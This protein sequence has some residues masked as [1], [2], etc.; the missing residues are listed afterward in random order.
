[1]LKPNPSINDR[2]K[3]LV[4][5]T[6]NYFSHIRKYNSVLTFISFSSILKDISSND[7]YCFKGKNKSHAFSLIQDLFGENEN[8][9]N[10]FQ[11]N[12]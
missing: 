7:L 3:N 5:N 11:Y 9:K 10:A 4:L 1:M 6:R 12:C 2:L 8:T